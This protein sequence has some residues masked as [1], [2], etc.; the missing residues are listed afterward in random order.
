M[1]TL[2]NWIYKTGVTGIT[3]RKGS[4]AHEDGITA[5]PTSSIKKI[6]ITDS[7]N[8]KDW[9]T[10]YIFIND[11]EFMFFMFTITEDDVDKVKL[12]SIDDRDI[13]KSVF[14]IIYEK[15]P[16]TAIPGTEINMIDVTRLKE[17]VL[18]D[19]MN[20]RNAEQK[21]KDQEISERRKINRSKIVK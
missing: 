2:E 3:P 8:D 9:K 18:T 19:L 20:K 13:L 11:G 5:V 4:Y 21:L 6:A 16:L 12:A 15:N 7:N 14:S 17:R 10:V 1:D